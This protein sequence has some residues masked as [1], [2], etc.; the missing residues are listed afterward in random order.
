MQISKRTLLWGIIAIL[1]VVT[2]FVAF[3]TGTGGVDVSSTGQA[4]SAG[5]S[6]ASSAMVGGC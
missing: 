5:Q 3:Q 6:A 4:V 2:L 1:F